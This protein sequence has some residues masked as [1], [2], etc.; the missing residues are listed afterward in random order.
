MDSKKLKAQEYYKIYN[1]NNKE[2]RH[3]LCR[4]Y[5]KK[6]ND[7]IKIKHAEYRKNNKI[8][9]KNNNKIQIMCTCGI[10]ISKINKSRHCKTKKH[11]SKIVN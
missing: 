4:E 10:F 5:Y 3:A 2:R 8:K 6:N 7:S 1:Q 11:L 9:I